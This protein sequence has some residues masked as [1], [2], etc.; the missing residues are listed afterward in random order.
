VLVRGVP[1]LLARTL[2]EDL[3]RQST[4]NRGDRALSRCVGFLGPQR[5]WRHT[6]S[7]QREDVGAARA[8]EHRQLT[9]PSVLSRF[10]H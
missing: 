4:V 5:R 9:T 3:L 1:T 8:S 2:F 7:A 10:P 6:G